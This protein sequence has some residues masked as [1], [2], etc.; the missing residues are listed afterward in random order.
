MSKVAARKR[1]FKAAVSA[2]LESKSQNRKIACV[3]TAK[4]AFNSNPFSWLMPGGPSKPE[5]VVQPYKDYQVTPATGGSNVRSSEPSFFNK[6]LNPFSYLQGSQPGQLNRHAPQLGRITPAMAGAKPVDT[7][8][9]WMKGPTARQRSFEAARPLQPT[10]TNLGK[11]YEP[12]ATSL[13][14]RRNRSQPSFADRFSQPP[15]LVGPPAPQLSVGEAPRTPPSVVNPPQMPGGVRPIPPSVVNPPQMPGGMPAEELDP[16]NP[17]QP[18]EDR[19]PPMPGRRPTPAPPLDGVPT[20]A[21]EL[22]GLDGMD[23][24]QLPDDGGPLEPIPMA[25][26]DGMQSILEN[27]SPSDERTGGRKGRR[28]GRR[29]GRGDWDQDKYEALRDRLNRMT[30]KRRKFLQSRIAK[31]QGELDGLGGG[32]SQSEPRSERIFNESP[33]MPY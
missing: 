20:R 32:S 7:Q 16:R 33:Y 28:G 24:G 8:V 26:E 10:P 22:P 11:A 5:Q 27:P 14:Y 21:P 30:T 13:V 4:L 2:A 12:D 18:T 25:D 3:Q 23:D 31:L 15:S 29:G 19:R 1:I 17:P 6:Y 9:P